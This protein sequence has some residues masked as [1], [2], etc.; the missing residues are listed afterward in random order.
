MW[1]KYPPSV[2]LVNEAIDPLTAVYDE[3]WLIANHADELTPWTPFIASRHVLSEF[4]E[5]AEIFTY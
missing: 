3:D 5:G 2:Q 4:P 1:D